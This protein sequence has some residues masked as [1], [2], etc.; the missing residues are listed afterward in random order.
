MLKVVRYPYLIVNCLI[1]SYL[2]ISHAYM[3]RFTHK[4]FCLKSGGMK[5]S[6]VDT[7][8]ILKVRVNK[9]KLWP[10]RAAIMPV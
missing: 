6:D 8:A 9:V 10:A 7:A 4:H 3:C 1:V 2:L 5:R